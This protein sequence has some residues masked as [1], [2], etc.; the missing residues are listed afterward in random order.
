MRRRLSAQNCTL[1]GERERKK[2][3]RDTTAAFMG[4]TDVRI[5]RSLLSA[6]VIAQFS[7]PSLAFAEEEKEERKQRITSKISLFLFH[8]ERTQTHE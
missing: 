7:L 1:S 4:K 5:G 6:L 8:S 3:K 2:K